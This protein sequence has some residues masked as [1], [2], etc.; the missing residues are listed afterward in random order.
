MER[1]H[2]GPVSG[3][4]RKSALDFSVQDASAA[5]PQNCQTTIWIVGFLPTGVNVT[6]VMDW[7]GY[8]GISRGYCCFFQDCPLSDVLQ[9]SPVEVEILPFCASA[10]SKLKI[11]P[12]SVADSEAGTT[13]TQ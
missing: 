2:N 7:P 3:S 1:G 8:G 9:T 6:L 10:N 5:L 13:R 11:S 4:K 12:L